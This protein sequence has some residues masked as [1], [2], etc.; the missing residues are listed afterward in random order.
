VTLKTLV[1][2]M[3][4][5]AMVA[6]AAAGVT[7]VASPAVSSAP[8][9]RPVVWDIPMPQAPAPDLQAPLLQTLQALAGGGA[10]SGKASYI[11]GGIGRIEGI[12]ADRA[13][14]RAAAEGKF[15][16]TFNI[17]NIDQEGG[18]ANADVT[19]TS[20]LGTTA[21]QNVQFVSG[22]S[23]TGWQIGKASALNLLSAAS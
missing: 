13:Y 9:V 3:A 23:P 20:A 11:Q 22:P 12:A 6:G 7:S 8:A 14:N 18:V 17:A 15:P 10:F 2:G 19:A 4:A 5:A 21:T 1:T 16:L